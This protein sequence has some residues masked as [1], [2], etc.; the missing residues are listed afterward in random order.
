MPML[1]PTIADYANDGADGGERPRRPQVE[2]P[3]DLRFDGDGRPDQMASH[4]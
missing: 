4:A 1:A 3:E 2:V